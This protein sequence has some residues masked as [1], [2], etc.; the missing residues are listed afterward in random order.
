MTLRSTILSIVLTFLLSVAASA[1]DRSQAMIQSLQSQGFSGIEVSRT[2]LGRTR[3]VATGSAGRREIVLNPN[4]GEVLRDYLDETET[5]TERGREGDGH[6]GGGGGGSDDSGSDD[7]SGDDSG[8]G[9]GGDDSGGGMGGGDDG[10]GDSGDGG[11]DGGG[12]DD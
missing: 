11:G 6:A 10:G 12:S 4:T 3:I 8:G 9:M 7:S 1:Q 5:E 2:W